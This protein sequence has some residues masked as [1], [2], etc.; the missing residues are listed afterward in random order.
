MDKPLNPDFT[1]KHI[2]VHVIH[3]LARMVAR[4]AGQGA[5]QE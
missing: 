5:A 4:E 2:N 1:F 3:I